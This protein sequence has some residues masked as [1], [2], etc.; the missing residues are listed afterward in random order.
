MRSIALV[1]AFVIAANTAV[2]QTA[3]PVSDA[4]R[5]VVHKESARLSVAAEMMP[6]DKYAIRPS[7]PE[8]TFGELVARAANVS[9]S[10]CA[11]IANR[12]PADGYAGESEPK[13]TLTAK[14]R[15]RLREC[16]EVLRGLTDAGLGETI[17][18]NGPKT[19]AAAISEVTAFWGELHQWMTDSMRRLGVI[20]PVPCT[21]PGGEVH[22]GGPVCGSGR[23]LCTSGRS[24][25]GLAGTLSDGPY[26]VRS[27]GG[28][29]LPGERNVFSAG[30]SGSA[31]LLLADQFTAPS[32]RRAF[33]ID[34][35][36]PA[37]AEGGTRK[38]IVRADNN[39]LVL[40]QLDVGADRRLQSMTAIPVGASV[41]AAQIAV[42]FPID[43]AVHVLQAGPQPVG[44]CFS[45]PTAIHGR[46]T[47][48]GTITRSDSSTWVIELP[49]GSVAR[50]FD[51][52]NRYPYAIDK[53]LYLVSLRLTLGPKQ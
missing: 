50:L 10:Y 42:E 6:A 11:R 25:A 8:A 41:P 47:S 23:N 13:D 14:L 34:L 24:P 31:S 2:G 52:R 48:V 32:E 29:Y 35:D 21:G 26:T 51:V 46:G 20:P 43:G 9:I 36:H 22:G 3:S 1:T 12:T 40:A 28:A 27:D 38:G 53:G 17:R 5:A 39:A 30:A 33:R 49:P 44:H 7:P 15:A 4:L 16:D 37:P 18:L 19:R 45:D